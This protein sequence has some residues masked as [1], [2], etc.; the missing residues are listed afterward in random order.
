M[1]KILKATKTAEGRLVREFSYKEEG[2]KEW[3]TLRLKDQDT[4][5]MNDGVDSFY[6]VTLLS[7]KVGYAHLLKGRVVFGCEAVDWHR[8]A[9]TADAV[10]WTENEQLMLK[11]IQPNSQV[12]IK[13]NKQVREL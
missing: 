8:Y 5:I 11:D 12:E 7:E 13:Y 10:V 3:Q 9:T 2:S 4:Q 1:T 6:L